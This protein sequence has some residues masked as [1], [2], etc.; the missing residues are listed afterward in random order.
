MSQNSTNKTFG[1]IS[2]DYTSFRMYESP[3]H[4]QLKE[5]I[6]NTN[7]NNNLN[8]NLIQ[9]VIEGGYWVENYPPKVIQHYCG[10][11][12][13]CATPDA[14]AKTMCTTFHFC[15][16]KG[17]RPLI[18]PQYLSTKIAINI[19]HDL[20]QKIAAEL[21]AK[22]SL[23][24]ITPGPRNN[25]YRTLTSERLIKS[26]NTEFG[27]YKLDVF[28]SAFDAYQKLCIL[29]NNNYIMDSTPEIKFATFFP[30]DLDNLII[31]HD[32]H[33]YSTYN[34]DLV[35][36]KP[37]AE[38]LD[39]TPLDTF[40]ESKYI[41]SETWKLILTVHNVDLPANMDTLQEILTLFT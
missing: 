28:D 25:I 22:I 23:L 38:M 20:Y 6:Q 1:V 37:V 21:E 26:A 27:I 41:P 11:N 8:I 17:V 5:I 14:D 36:I 24:Q 4:L 7:F 19:S 9:A 18:E 32:D 35:E 31:A 2:D 34:R 10:F 3:E 13:F 15:A 33:D 12:G 40:S 39:I 30:E 16:L 29:M